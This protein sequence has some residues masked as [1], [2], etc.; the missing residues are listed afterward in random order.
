[1][2]YC[3]HSSI[4]GAAL[5]LAATVSSLAAAEAPDAKARWSS[6]HFDRTLLS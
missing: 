4:I 3:K 1:M 5:L 2:P 6:P